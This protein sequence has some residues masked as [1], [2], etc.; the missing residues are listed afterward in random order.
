[1]QANAQG[2]PSVESSSNVVELRES[3]R[4]RFR[5]EN[6]FA[7]DELRKQEP[8]LRLEMGP[9]AVFSFLARSWRLNPDAW[10]SQKTIGANVAGKDSD[11]EK[12]VRRWLAPLLLGG[13]V[14]VSR[15]EY[16][17]RGG[18]AGHLCLEV[19]YAPGPVT[20]AAIELWAAMYP[21]GEPETRPR[22]LRVVRDP[23]T[24]PGGVPGTMPVE[25]PSFKSQPSSAEHSASPLPP[26]AD[27]GKVVP[28][29]PSGEQ[30][31]KAVAQGLE[32]PTPE[33]G[34]SS[35]SGSE[36]SNAELAHDAL[37]LHF[38]K[39]Y[40]GAR[41]PACW[42]TGPKS[43]HAVVIG[44]L[45]HF[46][47]TVA[48]RREFIRDAVAGAIAKSQGR[49][50]TI[51]Y[52]FSSVEYAIGHAE[53]GKR[54]RLAELARVKLERVRQ[55]RLAHVADDPNPALTS[56]EQAARAAELAKLLE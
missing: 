4:R 15:R 37:A 29:L 5:D 7:I 41:P 10:P 19:H 21:K 56:D 53:S 38:A 51:G 24:M 50:P 18:K 54:A 47:G 3:L 34:E 36:P 1:M 22:P 49:F 11:S 2:N 8:F 43:D 44:C 55:E 26:P 30:N 45:V 48:E 35:R 46:G 39:Q 23:G 17:W 16:V 40:P 27:A 12:S 28:A 13:L 52:V 6:G 25:P 32:R 33:R 31:E 42:S 20:V 9:W 14:V